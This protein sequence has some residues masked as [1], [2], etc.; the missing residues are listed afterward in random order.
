MTALQPTHCSHRPTLL[1]KLYWQILPWSLYCSYQADCACSASSPTQTRRKDL[2]IPVPMHAGNWLDVPQLPGTFIVNLGD[3]LQQWT[4]GRFR[5][6]LSW[7]M[8][9]SMNACL[10]SYPRTAAASHALCLTADRCM[11]IP[12]FTL[13]HLLKRYTWILSR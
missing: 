6:G 4:N 9:S 10:S 8:D 3:M 13:H 11:C 5:S 12:T 1:P 7:E 2:V